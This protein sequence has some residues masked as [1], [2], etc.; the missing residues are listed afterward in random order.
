MIQKNYKYKD[1]LGLTKKKSAYFFE[2]NIDDSKLK[3][4]KGGRGE[5]IFYSITD[6]VIGR[7]NVI[8]HGET[9]KGKL[10]CH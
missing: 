5:H 9:P 4:L 8:S 1:K 3:S 7:E 10:G 2:F 6:L